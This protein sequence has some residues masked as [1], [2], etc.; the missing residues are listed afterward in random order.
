M[1]VIVGVVKDEGCGGGAAR[2][3]FAIVQILPPSILRVEVLQVDEA[4]E[5]GPDEVALVLNALLREDRAACD[6]V[7]GARK[8]EGAGGVVG[9]VRLD[10]RRRST[11][12]HART[13][14]GIGGEPLSPLQTQPLQSQLFAALATLPSKAVPDLSPGGGEA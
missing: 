11:G 13:A 3:W 5:C 1:K 9:G 10:G 8:R 6:L 7:V 12:V 4:V 2:P 14:V